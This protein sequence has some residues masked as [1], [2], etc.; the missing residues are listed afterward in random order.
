MIRKVSTH[1]SYNM[2]SIGH[3]DKFTV[4]IMAVA[5]SFTLIKWIFEIQV[6]DY[7][8]DADGD[9]FVYVM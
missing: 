5:Q 1:N 6:C 4:K 9:L 2:H 8:V 3:R 7:Y